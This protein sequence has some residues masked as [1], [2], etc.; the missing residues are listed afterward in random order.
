[1]NLGG[2]ISGAQSARYPKA[3]LS[4]F[5]NPVE[6]RLTFF[7]T[8]GWQ[9]ANQWDMAVPPSSVYPVAPRLS[10]VQAED[11]LTRAY[12]S[13]YN[14]PIPGTSLSQIYTS[15]PIGN[16]YVMAG[17]NSTTIESAD[18]FTA[19]TQAPNTTVVA[20]FASTTPSGFHELYYLWLVR[21]GGNSVVNQHP[22]Q[23]LMGFVKV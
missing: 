6:A 4:N 12:V 16:V 13:I 17:L 23:G 14:D 22:R 9:T 20:P 10:W 8:N 7:F 11:T 5:Y 15:S 2:A 1:M 21:P 18:A 19:E 3:W